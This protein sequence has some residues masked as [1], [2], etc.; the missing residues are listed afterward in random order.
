MIRNLNDETIGQVKST[1]DETKI[2]QLAKE[3]I[4]SFT[5]KEIYLKTDEDGNL[6][7]KSVQDI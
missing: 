3:N 2:Q 5:K 6:Y 4:D 7:V 1:E